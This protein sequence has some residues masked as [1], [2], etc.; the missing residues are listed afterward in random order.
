MSCSFLCQVFYLRFSCRSQ[1]LNQP[2]QY[3]AQNFHDG[4][5]IM[6]LTPLS[7]HQGKP[8]K[9][10]KYWAILLNKVHTD[11]LGG[12]L[13]FTALVILISKQ[14]QSKY[15]DTFNSALCASIARAA[16]KQLLLV[17]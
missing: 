15:I 16:I 1:D 17:A 2:F 6:T 13:G 4:I 11:G 14:L 3:I 12:V 5:V 7:R 10:F 8:P 9:N